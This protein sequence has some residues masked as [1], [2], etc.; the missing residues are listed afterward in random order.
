MNR[1]PTRSSS[2]GWA[3]SRLIV[4]PFFRKE[5]LFN[6]RVVVPA[7]GVAGRIERGEIVVFIVPIVVVLNWG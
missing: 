5:G 4:K 6:L 2:K 7:S 1:V 3:N